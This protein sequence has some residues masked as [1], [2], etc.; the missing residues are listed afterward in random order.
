[1]MGP[2]VTLLLVSAATEP[3]PEPGLI[4]FVVSLA[5]VVVVGGAGGLR[6]IPAKPPVLLEESTRRILTLPTLLL[7]PLLGWP[8]GFA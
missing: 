5:V 6:D 2:T 3:Y 8:R 7:L 4:R 1:M